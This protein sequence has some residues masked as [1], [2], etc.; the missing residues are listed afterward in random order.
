MALND[1]TKTRTH[2]LGHAWLEE[3]VGRDPEAFA[4]IAE[5]ILKYVERSNPNLHT[6]LLVRT[7]DKPIDEVLTEYMEMVVEGKFDSQDSRTRGSIPLLGWMFNHA[8]KKATNSDFDFDFLGERD[9]VNFITELAKKIN[10]GTITLEKHGKGGEQDLSKSKIAKKAQKLGE[11]AKKK[12]EKDKKKKGDGEV[13]VRGFK[14]SNPTLDNIAK[15]EKPWTQKTWEEGKDPGWKKAMRHIE[16]DPYVKSIIYNK[17][18]LAKKGVVPRDWVDN[19]I[20]SNFFQNMIKRFN[21]K[22]IGDKRISRWDADKSTEQ[23]KDKSIKENESIFAYINSQL[24]WRAD[25]VFNQMEQ[26]K[27]PSG[28]ISTDAR[29]PD[30]APVVQPSDTDTQMEKFEEQDMTIR[31]KMGGCI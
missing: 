7:Q 20:G 13:D 31:D 3:A 12:R 9:A 24:R 26:G 6:E 22:K 5:Q 27:V 18:K 2:E 1:K 19:V 29:T 14:M 25:D 8:A 4:G 16:K 28:T 17:H 23:L 10:N 15:P 30:G 21:T 11:K